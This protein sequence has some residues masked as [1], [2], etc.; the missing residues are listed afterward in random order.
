MSDDRA[1]GGGERAKTNAEC[2]WEAAREVDRI[3]DEIGDVLNAIFGAEG[4]DDFTTDPYDRS[5]E[6]FGVHRDFELNATDIGWLRSTGFDRA[7]THVH[8]TKTHE[9]GERQYGLRPAGSSG[10]STEER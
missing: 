10:S 4:W 3:E 8:K 9:P 7:W 1:A 2:L 6:V 5:I